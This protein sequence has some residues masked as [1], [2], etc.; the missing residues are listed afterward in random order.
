[1]RIAV[2]SGG[3][4]SENDVSLRSGKAGARGLEDAGQ[5]A[6]PAEISAAGAWSCEGPAGDL[7]PG[8]GQRAAGTAVP[9]RHGPFGEDGSAQGVLEWLDLPYVGSDVLGSAVCMGKLSLKRLFAQAGVAQVDFVAA[10]ESGWR[11]RCEE[12]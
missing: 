5:E 3:R 1:M 12:M 6:L 9:P 10:G 8:A 2:L 7:A 4:S 11:E